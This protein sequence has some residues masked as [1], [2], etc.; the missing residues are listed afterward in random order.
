MTKFKVGDKV[1]RLN[2][3]NPST[4]KGGI[5][6]VRSINFNVIFL[7]GYDISF[8]TSNFSLLEE[9]DGSFEVG[10]KYK[11]F[12]LSSQYTYVGPFAD[13]FLF[14]NL[15]SLGDVTTYLNDHNIQLPDGDWLWTEVKEPVVSVNYTKLNSSGTRVNSITNS[16]KTFDDNIKITTT[17]G[18]VTNVEFLQN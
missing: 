15:N 12:L 16:E 8:L 18:I 17:D 7:E 10:K 1:V 11:N 4:V 2:S 5:Y 6:T 3:C 9:W 14:A 13:K